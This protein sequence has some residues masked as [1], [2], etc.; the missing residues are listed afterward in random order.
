[1][2]FVFK[3]AGQAGAGVMTTGRALVKCFSRSGYNAIGYPEYPS[4]VR[5]GHNTVQVRVRDTQI[6]SPLTSQDLVLALN[7]DAIFYHM[8]SM[9]KDGIII[10]DESID[11]TKFTVRSDVRMYP[12][13][14]AKLTQEAGGTEQMKNTAA[15]GAALAAVDYPFAVLEGIIRDDFK[16]KGEEVI[17]K[18]ASAAKAGYEYVK[19]KGIK[20]SKTLAPISESRSIIITGNEAISLGAIQG[21]LKFFAAYPMTPASSIL[22]YLI[23][24]ERK[25]NLVVKQTEDELAAMN[26]AIGAS[27]AGARSMTSTSG[28]GFALMT[29]ALGLAAMS[30]TPVVAVLVQR[31]GPSTGLP[32]WTEQ[33]D[34]RM[35]LHASQ[36]D[37]IRVVLAPGDVQECFFLTAEAL[38]LA[39][40]YQIPV[41]V[42]SDKHLSETI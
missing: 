5:G 40:K 33:G 35:A 32:T 29:E 10:Y 39:D 14:L 11:A 36:G 26:Y 34:L 12:L 13:P 25:F 19:G 37:F 23:D 21:G 31:S 27:F 41:I 8:S 3:I 6:S 18:N 7:K 22:H 38:N 16:R 28:G 2:D 24:N 9:A 4:L 1:M 15:L 20:A 17:A 42:L 30:E